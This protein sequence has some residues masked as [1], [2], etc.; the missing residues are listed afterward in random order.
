MVRVP[1]STD[2]QY[3][4][5]SPIDADDAQLAGIQPC[6][7]PPP[8]AARVR[9]R[10]AA[11]RGWDRGRDGPQRRAG[12]HSAI[13]KQ[14]RQPLRNTNRLPV[15]ASADASASLPRRFGCTAVPPVGEPLGRCRRCLDGPLRTLA[16]WHPSRRLVDPG[17]PQAPCFRGVAAVGPSECWQPRP[18]GG[19]SLFLPSGDSKVLSPQG[20]AAWPGSF[21]PPVQLCETQQAPARQGS[22][23]NPL[24]LQSKKPSSLEAGYCQSPESPDREERRCY[25][26]LSGTSDPWKPSPFPAAELA[27]RLASGYPGHGK[28]AIPERVKGLLWIPDQGDPGAAAGPSAM[29]GGPGKARGQV[30]AVLPEE[31]ASPSAKAEKVS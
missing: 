9:Q 11:D 8:T 6:S 13:L 29:P 30:G 20:N 26:R 3:T 24:A 15:A 23:W 17:P 27:S 14:R 2:I 21:L 7:L 31:K 28:R 16:P 5:E 25:R 10:P 22:C 4:I 18:T 1:T 19:G 12:Q